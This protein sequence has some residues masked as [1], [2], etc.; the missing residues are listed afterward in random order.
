VTAK[1]AVALV[2]DPTRILAAQ[3]L[4]ADPWQ[5]KLL[6][7]EA[8][9][10]LL[11][12]SRGAGKT[13]VTSELALHTALFQPNSLVLPS[14]CYRFAFAPLRSVATHLRRLARAAN[15]TASSRCLYQVADSWPQWRGQ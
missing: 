3:G 12:C 13:R 9:F 7:S 10:L 6:F 11:N 4:R 1:E 5:R 15:R 2:V 14:L 8:S